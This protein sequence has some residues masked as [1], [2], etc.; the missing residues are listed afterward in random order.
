MPDLWSSRSLRRPVVRTG[1]QQEDSVGGLRSWWWRRSV[2]FRRAWRTGVLLVVS[3]LACLVLGLTTAQATS[4]VGPH[5]AV[6]QTTLNSQLALDLGPLGTAWATSPVAPVG[7]RVTIG[8]I[9]GAEDLGSSAAPADAAVSADGE[10]NQAGS[11]GAAGTQPP[12]LAGPTSPRGEAQSSASAQASLGGIGLSVPPE[13]ANQLGSLVS[14]DGA[15]YLSL[16]S[17]PELTVRAGARAL[18]GDALRRAGLAWSVTLCL[19][20]AGRLASG[21]HL[22][23]AV[24]RVLSRPL[25]AGLGAVTVV[26]SVLALLVPAVTTASAGGTT[27]QALSGTPLAA[28]HFSG[29]LGDVVN[30]YGPALRTAVDASD[31]FYRRLGANLDRAW[32]LSQELDG[33]VEVRL[34][35]DGIS[36]SAGRELALRAAVRRLDAAA[37]LRQA[38]RTDMRA[39][40]TPTQESGLRGTATSDQ[41]G[42]ATGEQDA[43]MSSSIAQAGGEAAGYETG[44]AGAGSRADD[45]G[46]SDPRPS[47]LASQ[48]PLASPWPGNVQRAED[49]A[50]GSIPA[51]IPLGGLT[52]PLAVS[53]PGTRFA[54]LTTDL[55]CNLDVIRLAGRLDT[56]AG[57]SLHL[58]GGDLTMTGSEP[59]QICV[60]ALSAA[61]P[62]QVARAATIGN[63]DSQT[64]AAQLRG[65][66]WTVMDGSVVEV[67][68]LRLLGDV[69]PE[70]TVPGSSAPR[71]RENAVEVGRRLAQV[72]CAAPERPD[73]VLIH[74]P[75][76][77]WPIAEQGCVPLL[78]AG[79][80]HQEHGVTT[81]PGHLGPV[82]ELRSG[83][84]LGGMSI[85]P[86]RQDAYLHVLAFDHNAHLVGW[87]ALVLH[88]DASVT[89]G[90]WQ[91][92]PVEGQTL[93]EVA[94]SV[95]SEE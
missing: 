58:D 55:H 23:D 56:L 35:D 46:G 3:G 5:T 78:L 61:V 52:G 31:D 72:S 18:L 8:E 79:H 9:P 29:R 60:D 40:S 91:E 38:H 86:L 47:H 69:D 87:R 19:V 51:G 17:H 92:V 10:D 33:M 54:V 7:V 77:F 13:L 65:R 89:V 49:S 1:P 63:H 95:S 22:R 39:A 73:L 37:R 24:C 41:A 68:G 85:G 83:A 94:G 34:G 70:R 42:S 53:E 12:P 26:A 28:T 6:W 62:Q 2:A 81:V 4:P 64:T 27:V 84:A 67:G 82:T 57:A 80:T 59:E 44:A 66:G 48:V 30:V 16:I 43:S 25:A 45:A 90:A 15:A 71:G 88:P 36:P 76:T 32:A 75:Y 20:A 93:G 74:Q 14:A 50:S 11:S 21:G